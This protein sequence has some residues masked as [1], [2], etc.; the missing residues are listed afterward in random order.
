M[1]IKNIPQYHKNKFM[2]KKKDIVKSIL[3][4]NLIDKSTKTGS[5]L[6]LVLYKAF[7]IDLQVSQYEKYPG[8]SNQY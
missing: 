4:I 2:K 6:T 5:Q 8:Y 1:I 3:S 7:K